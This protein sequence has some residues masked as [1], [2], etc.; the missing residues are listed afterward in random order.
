M[1]WTPPAF[2]RHHA[3]LSLFAVANDQALVLGTESIY[4]A[5]FK[6][7]N[8]FNQLT[9]Q[10]LLTPFAPAERTQAYPALWVVVTGC[11]AHQADVGA[12]ST[13]DAAR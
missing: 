10:L 11:Q 13:T 5:E 8:C 2:E 7:V 4:V 1:R 9:K 6:G 3:G 12:G